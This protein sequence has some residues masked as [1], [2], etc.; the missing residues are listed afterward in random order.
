MAN[1]PSTFAKVNDI[2]VAQDAP[3]TEALMGKMGSNDN[4]LKDNLDDEIVDRTAADT[5]ITT[6]I[7]NNVKGP[8]PIQTLTTLKARMDNAK[9]V[10]YLGSAQAFLNPVN[11]AFISTWFITRDTGTF[12]IQ[13]ITDAGSPWG[14]SNVLDSSVPVSNSRWAEM[15]VEETGANVAPSIYVWNFQSV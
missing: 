8:G 11:L 15:N 10:I 2:E 3:V 13:R 4:Y 9:N 14:R 7:T 6:D 1:L 12:R 5:A